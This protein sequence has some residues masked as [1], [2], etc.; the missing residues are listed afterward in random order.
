MGLLTKVTR[1]IFAGELAK[2]EKELE[3]NIGSQIYQQLLRN[4]KGMPVYMPDNVESYIKDGYL[5]NP[6]VYA[7]VSTIAQKAA[8]N[9]PWSVYE[10]KNDKALGLYKCAA[11]DLPQYKREVIKT[12]ALVPIESHD[13]NL[14]F[15]N[16]NQL[17]TWSELVE[18]AVGFKLVTGETYLHC[19]GPQNGANSGKIKEVWVL[20]SQ[21]VVIVAGDKTQPVKQYELVG[22]RTTIIPYNQVIHLKYW[23]PNYINGQFLHGISPIQAGRRVVT[24]S[25]SS[26][27]AMVASFQNMGAN[28]ILS[29]RVNSGDQALTEEQAEMIKQRYKREYAG[30]KNAGKPIITSAALEWQQMGMSPVD[31]NIIESDKMDLRSLCRI[32]KYP[33]ELM[34]DAENKTYSNTKEAGSAA[35][36][37]AIIPALVQLRDA[38]NKFIKGKYEDNIYIDFD[39]SMVSELQDDLT[40]MATALGGAWWIKPNEKRDLMSFGADDKN[41]LMDDYWVPA[42]YVPMSGSLLEDEAIEEVEKSLK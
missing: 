11:Y 12:K 7:I 4:V 1:S 23:T 25:N 34:G 29:G 33:S 31:L 9:I 21:I 22:D 8:T 40:E 17:Q 39:T 35:Y 10:V 20:P 41:P 37:N 32:Y 3:K 28:G 16:P 18:Q 27:D 15:Q 2:L 14:I 36:T 6:N 5:F 13:L 24:R 38:L 26:Y 42:G 19:I 30:P